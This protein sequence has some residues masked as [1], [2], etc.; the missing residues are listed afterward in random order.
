[1]PVLTGDPPIVVDALSG[2]G[3]LEEVLTGN[4]TIV[5]CLGVFA[6]FLT[7]PV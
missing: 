7:T 3:S 6:R 4:A 2:R 1:V 5:H